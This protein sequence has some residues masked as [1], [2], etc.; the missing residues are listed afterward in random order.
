MI[1]KRIAVAIVLILPFLLA[2][3]EKQ[4]AEKTFWGSFTPDKTYSCDRRYYALQSVS[5][6]S[7]VVTVYDAETHEAAGSFSPGRARDF[8]GVCWEKE[9]L[10]LWAQSADVGVQCFSYQNGQWARNDQATMPDYIVSKYDK[11]YRD[12]PELWDDIY[13]SPTE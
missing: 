1:K 4:E 7:I 11:A 10:N 3:C 5:D 8:W 12:H 6:Q 13:T 2:A 9:T